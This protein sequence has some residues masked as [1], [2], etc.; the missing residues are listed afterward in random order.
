[1]LTSMRATPSC[2]LFHC[3]IH[4]DPEPCVVPAEKWNLMWCCTLKELLFFFEC[5]EFCIKWRQYPVPII[6]T[7]ATYF[8]CHKLSDLLGPAFISLT[9]NEYGCHL[10]AFVVQSEILSSWREK[11]QKMIMSVIIKW[12]GLVCA[13]L[14]YKVLW[15]RKINGEE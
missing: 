10:H 11:S 5:A 7:A 8:Y 14:D 6:S 1:M 4:Y 12:S 9:Y 3:S 15:F 13:G 2:S